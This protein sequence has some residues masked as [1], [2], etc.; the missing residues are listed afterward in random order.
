MYAF[1]WVVSLATSV[2]KSPVESKNIESSPPEPDFSDNASLV[3]SGEIEVAIISFEKVRSSKTVPESDNLYN[4]VPKDA[5]MLPEAS[6][7]MVRFPLSVSEISMILLKNNS[8][9][10]DT[11]LNPNNIPAAKLRMRIFRKRKPVS[12]FLTHSTIT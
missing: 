11:L 5:K 12:M 10:A 1:V 8:S 2:L 6:T 9:D 4:I 3:E 7:S